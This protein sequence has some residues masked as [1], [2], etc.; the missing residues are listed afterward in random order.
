MSATVGQ[1]RLMN[2][3][4][5][6]K[7]GYRVPRHLEQKLRRHYPTVRVAWNRTFKRWMLIER[8][9][10]GW[11]PIGLLQREDGSYVRPTLRN[12]VRY[13]HRC[14]TANLRRHFAFKRWLKSLDEPEQ[15]EREQAEGRA[16]EIIIEGSKALWDA[17]K[18]T[19]VTPR[20]RV[21]FP[22][23][24]RNPWLRR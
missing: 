17:M 22:Q 13:L 14:S 1:R 6:G 20:P 23:Q 12:T 21:W 2:F 3:T 8:T 19:V 7:A 4:L 15:R 11:S 10:H 24:R 18:K 5:R 9:R 16:S